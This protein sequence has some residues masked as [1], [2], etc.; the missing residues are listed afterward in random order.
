MKDNYDEVPPSVPLMQFLFLVVL[1]FEHR[2]R[3]D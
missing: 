3:V 2:Y 1:Q